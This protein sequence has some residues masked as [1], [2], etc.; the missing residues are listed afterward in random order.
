MFS[1]LAFEVTGRIGRKMDQTPAPICIDPTGNSSYDWPEIVVLPQF[2][3][4]N[5]LKCRAAVVRRGWVV[6]RSELAVWRLSFRENS[7]KADDKFT[8]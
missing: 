8:V 2:W 6:A 1:E 3:P 4:G 7:Q 5:L